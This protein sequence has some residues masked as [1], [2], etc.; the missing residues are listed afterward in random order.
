M[1]T[2]GYRDDRRGRSASRRRTRIIASAR[3]GRVNR[4]SIASSMLS[5]PSSTAATAAA[6]GM[7]MPRCARHLDQHG[8]REGALRELGPAL[9][10]RRRLAFAERDAEREVA[11]LRARA[12]EDEVAQAGQAGQRLGLRPEGAAETHQLGEAARRERRRGARAEPA[13]GH[14]SRRD[15]Q[16]VLGGAADLD[17]AH[18]GRMIGAEARRADRLGQ[19]GGKR[20]RRPPR[21]SRRSACRARRRRRSS[22]PRGSPAPRP[23]RTRRSPRS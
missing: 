14:D 17:P 12:G 2:T 13:S 7:S 3:N 20:R 4:D 19:R 1:T 6:I 15:R 5:L 9:R 22:G 11:R 8:R 18:I 10:L 16:H 21:A 23:A